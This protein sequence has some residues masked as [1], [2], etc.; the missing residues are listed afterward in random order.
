MTL[1]RTSLTKF[2]A[3][4]R[5]PDPEGAKRAARQLWHERGIVVIF[6]DDEIPGLARMTVEAVAIAKYGRR[7][8]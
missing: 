6:E 1:H 5:D 2:A 7:K 4:M 3:A 8:K